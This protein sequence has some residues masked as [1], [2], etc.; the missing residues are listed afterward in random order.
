[1]PNF[2]IQR[3]NFSLVIAIFISLAGLLAIFALPVAQYPSVAPPQVIIKATYPGASAEVINNTVISLIEEEL[4]GAKGLL[5]YESQSNSSGVAETTVTF[6]PGTNPDLAQVDVQNRIKRVESRLPQAVIQQGLQLEQASSSFLLIY[7]LTYKDAGKDQVGLA[8]YAARNIN[9]E[10][11]RV[12]GVGRV[13]MFAAER[14][15]RIWIDP[16]KLVGYGLSVDE[17]NKAIAAQNVQVSGGSTGEQPSPATQE[18]T[19][20]IMVQGQLTSIPEFEGIVLRANADGSTV[21]L[22]DVARIELGRQDYRLSSRLNGQPAAAMGVQ[23]APGAN[24]LE[25][26]KGIKARLAELSKNFP[27][28]IEYSVPFDTSIFVEVAI[29]KVLMTL[30]EAVVLV[31]LVML[32]F[33]QNFRYTLIPT[34]V[35]PICLLGTLAVM[36]PLGFSVNMM[37]MFGMVLAIGILVDDAIVVVENVERL[38][39]DEGLSPKEATIK[40]MGQ[41]SGA[42]VGITLVL[43]AVFLP[44]AFMTGSVGVIYRQFSVSL[45]VSILFSGFLALTLTPALSILLLKPIEKGHHEKKGFFGWFNRVFARMTERYSAINARLLARTG[46]MMLLY[47]VLVGALGYVYTSLPSAFL[48][49]EDQGYMNTDVQLPPGATLSRTLETTQQLE[50]YLGTRPAVSDVLTLQGFSFSGQ[51]QNAGLGF[52]MFKDWAQRA[53]GESAM[54]EADQANQDLAAV[55]DG[56]LFSVVPPSVE[57]MGNSSGFA[58]RLQD[59]AGLGRDALLSATETLMKKVYE[60]PKVF[61]YILIEG[62]SDAP[63]LDLRIDRSKAEALGVSFDAIN[64]ALSTAFGSALV[65]EFPNQG[66]MQRVIV[67][68]QPE[69]RDTPE[70]VAKLNVLNRAGELVPLE[71]FSEIGWKHGPVQL[72]RYN[73]YPSIK[74]IGDAAAGGSTGDAMKEI[75]R[76][77]SELPAGIGFEWTGLSFQ[78]KATGS[79]AP[80]LLALALL[81]VF[82]VLVALYESWKIPASVLLIVP[83]GALGAVAAVIVAGLPNDVY[84]K[85]GLV[86]IIGLAAKNAILI[87]EFAKDLH[88]QGRTLKEAAIE[89]A[90]LRFRPIVMTSVAFI[91]G[92]VP[93]VIATGAGA[94]SQ[95]AIGTGVL[96]GMLSATILGVL[97]VPVFFVWTLSVFERRK[98]QPAPS[99][100]AT[101]Q[102]GEK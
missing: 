38:M 70:S 51:G 20:S 102:A 83:V 95:R 57:G 73:G 2:F 84:F 44:L 49:T 24:A 35:V 32:L 98:A 55:P 100:L 11:R 6:E 64:S 71:S 52:V 23:L 12:P 16:A 99:Q 42:I 34:I 76:L 13:Q 48:P 66:R 67:Q 53:K 15:L 72:I 90:R 33:L 14:A 80:M 82:L 27:G 89:A 43:A 86:T 75:E 46:R 3:P 63:E 41:I 40:A 65:N 26:A 19:A 5:Y 39:A 96:G 29:S 79:Q 8:D 81:V 101:H 97:F 45:A 37:T 50:G 17:V 25:T 60:N 91:L 1:M 21:R 78:E 62:L 69:S 18:I 10:I 7:A 68:A 92:V 58:L 28:D 30:A 93:L 56:V 54:A 4:N 88:E 59:R 61:S 31:F 94:T 47:A 36:L 87:I 77:I 85:V 9:N 22:G 74:L